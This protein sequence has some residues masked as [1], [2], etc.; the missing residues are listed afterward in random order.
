MCHT[1]TS[2]QEV[3]YRRYREP[4]LL[5]GLDLRLELRSFSLGSDHIRF[6][7][8]QSHPAQN[9]SQTA[10]VIVILASTIPAKTQHVVP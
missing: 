2:R 6:Y 10:V 1:P 4:C 3:S 8:A 7:L 9:G 5:A